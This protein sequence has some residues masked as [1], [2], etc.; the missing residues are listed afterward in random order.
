MGIAYSVS[1]IDLIPGIIPVAG[2]LD[3]LLV[4]LRCLE[5]VLDAADKEITGPYLEE[6]DLSIEELKEDIQITSSTLKA[7]GRDTVKV[8]KNTGK[9][10]GYLL[11]YGIKKLI[12]KKPY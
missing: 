11:M 2:Q 1:P 3:N 9:T 7:I 10:A 4:M 6:V 8:M 5:K 12:G